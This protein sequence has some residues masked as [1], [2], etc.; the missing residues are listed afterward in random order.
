VNLITS[1]HEAPSTQ[2]PATPELLSL[3]HQ[4][5]MGAIKSKF[6]LVVNDKTFYRYK[7][8]QQRHRKQLTQSDFFDTSS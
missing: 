7:R 6:S 2:P 4:A 8:F 5:H 1:G 3:E